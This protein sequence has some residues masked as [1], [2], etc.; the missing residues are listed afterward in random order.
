MDQ[1]DTG[2]LVYLVA[3]L[4]ALIFWFRPALRQGF[5]KTVQQMLIWGLIFVGAVVVIGTWEDIRQTVQPYQVV[6]KDE[7]RIEIPVSRDGHYYLTAEVNG[8]PIRFV[9]DTGASDLVLNK[10]DAEKVGIRLED[11]RYFGRASTANG[12]VRTSIVRLD[13]IVVGPHVDRNFAASVTE[14]E[15]RESLLGMSYLRN[16]EQITIANGLLILTRE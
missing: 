5:S 11:L 13:E 15:M 8:E 3:L 12:V 6:V 9:V 7:N 4:A 14:G 10:S 16:F 2:N 1:I